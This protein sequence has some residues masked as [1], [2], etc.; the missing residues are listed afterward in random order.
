MTRHDLDRPAWTSLTSRHAAFAEGGASAKRYTP[1]IVP[2]AATRDDTPESLAALA[3]LLNPGETAVFLQAGE[4][5]LP[6]GL[7]DVMRAAGVQLVADGPI[8][9][10]DETGIAPLSRQDAEE[11]LALATLTKPGPFTL[12]ALDIGRFWGVREDGRLVAMAG[13]RMAQD[14]YV[15]ISGVCTHPDV[16]GRGL[17]RKLSCYVAH[18][19]VEGGDRPY[20]HAYASNDAAIKLYE[21]IGFTVRAMMNVAVFER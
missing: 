5:P 17:A 8:K 2:F 6:P 20:L 16:R 9:R 14:G 19:I 7:R 1:S 3:D 15:E 13:Q 21:A 12:N 4:I 11:M 10:D 18:R